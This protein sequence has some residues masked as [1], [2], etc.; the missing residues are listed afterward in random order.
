MRKNGEEWGR[1]RKRKTEEE[2]RG[3]MNT[4]EEEA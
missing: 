4:E 2:W 3:V 1:Q